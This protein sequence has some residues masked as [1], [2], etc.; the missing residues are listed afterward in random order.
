MRT[1]ICSTLSTSLMWW[2]KEEGT[3]HSI[4]GVVLSFFVSVSGNRGE[5]VWKIEVSEEKSCNFKR[6]LL[7]LTLNW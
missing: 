3:R 5:F 4:M 7:V 6:I 1:M 2:N